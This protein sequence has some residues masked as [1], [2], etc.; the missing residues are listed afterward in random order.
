MRTLLKIVPLVATA[1]IVAECGSNTGNIRISPAVADAKNY[2]EGVVPF[3]ASGPSQLTWCIGTVN[4]D[5]NGLVVSPAVI[6]STGHAH[7]VQGQSGTVTVLAGTGGK[8]VNPDAGEQLSSFGTAQL[9][10]P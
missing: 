7:C 3:T 4:G 10:C 9:T 5:C 8:V 6:D 1:V 2:P